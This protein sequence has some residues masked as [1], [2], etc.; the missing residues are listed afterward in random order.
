M[1]GPPSGVPDPLGTEGPFQ[2]PD[3]VPGELRGYRQFQLRGDGLY[4]MV[5][6]EFGAWD[7]TFERAACATGGE[8]PAPHASCRCGLY[9]WYLPGSA[10]VAIGPVSAVVTARGRCILGDRGFRAAASRIE[11]VALPP[12][13]RWFPPAAT[14]ARRMLAEHYPDTAV[15]TSTRRMLDD[16]PPHDVRA[17]GIEP[18]RDHSRGY[19]TTA[20]WLWLGLVMLGYSLVAFP[21]GAVDHAAQW[22]PVIVVLAVAWQVALVWVFVRLVALQSPTGQRRAPRGPG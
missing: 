22:W 4:P 18:P 12:T 13:I 7:G 11:A 3:L 2:G 6:V 15:Y 8:H 1:S 16:F 20:A 17:L 5:H 10:T 9:A 19:R 14:R 21:R